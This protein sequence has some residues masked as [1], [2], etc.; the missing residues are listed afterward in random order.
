MEVPIKIVNYS[1]IAIPGIIILVIGGLASFYLAYNFYPEKHE[2]VNIDG[3]CYELLGQAHNEYVDLSARKEI[4][5]LRLLLDKVKPYNAILPIIMSGRD[6]EIQ[7]LSNKYHFDITSQEKVKYYSNLD[8]S[9]ITANVSR[10][11]F[12][13]MINDLSVNDFYPSS[14]SVLGSIGLEPNKYISD[15][16]G[17]HIS[18]ELDNFMKNEIRKIVASS[19]GVEPAECRNNKYVGQ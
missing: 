17:K 5:T 12:A 1:Q 19:D 9:V 11:T 4:E 18:L 10:P 13:K 16:D 7:N 3:K 14:K 8:A 6:S 2:N 15:E